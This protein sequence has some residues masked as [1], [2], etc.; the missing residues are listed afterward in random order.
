M[1]LL[2]LSQGH[3][4]SDHPGYHDALIKLKD[5]G[6]IS[7]FLNLP[8]FGYAK[9]HGWDGFYNEV[10]RLCREENFDAVFFQYFHSRNI[11]N[12]E[13]CVEN[14]RNLNN[15]PIIITSARRWLFR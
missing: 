2:F 6:F 7:D 9:E 3:K 10:F 13:K 8:F 5:E 14:L 11:Q 4:T 15:P 12:P 1:K